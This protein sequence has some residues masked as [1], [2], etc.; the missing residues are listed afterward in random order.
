M[1]RNVEMLT[2][3]LLNEISPK[4]ANIH[5]EVINTLITESRIR[6]IVYGGNIWELRFSIDG[7]NPTFIVFES[8]IIERNNSFKSNRDDGLTVRDLE[9]IKTCNHKMEETIKYLI[10][11]NS[12][13]HFIKYLTLDAIPTFLNHKQPSSFLI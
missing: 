1:N 8:V 11:N 2:K 5:S 13:D 7:Q 12:I 6:D 4:D 9:D 3:A 10:R